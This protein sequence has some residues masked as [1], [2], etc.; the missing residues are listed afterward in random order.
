MKSIKQKNQM[1]K[2]ARAGVKGL[3]I[4]WIDTNPLRDTHEPIN[5]EV[6][7]KNPLFKL[8]AKKV[9][10]DFGDWITFGQP[11][12]WLITITVIFDYDN[13]QRQLEERELEAFATLDR[14]NEFS[15]DAIRDAMRHGDMKKYV[16]TKFKVECLDTSDRRNAA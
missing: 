11:F 3:I 4:S 9:F 7:H 16:H 10:K 5:G 13:G 14:I 12:H 8:V 15:L 1:L 6:T 2:R